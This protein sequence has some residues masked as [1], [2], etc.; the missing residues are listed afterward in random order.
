MKSLFVFCVAICLLVACADV[1]TPT[2]TPES[3]QIREEVIEVTETA[4]FPTPIAEIPEPTD[5]VD[6][7]PTA[8][9]TAT[10]VPTQPPTTVPTPI[11]PA[12]IPPAIWT[13][14]GTLMP[15]VQAILSPENIT[16]I[17]EVGRWGKGKVLDAKYSPDGTELAVATALGV[18][19]YDAETAVQLS[20]IPVENI[21]LASMAISPDWQWVAMGIEP[22]QI[23]IRQLSDGRLL[24]TFT[25][26]SGVQALAFTADGQHLLAPYAAWRMS[27]GV[28]IPSNYAMPM[29][30]NG[31]EAEMSTLS[32]DGK[33]AAL[34]QD[35]AYEMAELTV[36]DNVNVSTTGVSI[37]NDFYDYWPNAAIS[38]Y[39]QLLAI[40]ADHRVEMYQVSD[41]ALLFT[42]NNPV[43]SLVDGL[44]FTPDGQTLV[45]IGNEELSLWRVSDGSFLSRIPDAS[46]DI[47]FSADGKRLAAWSDTLTQWE[48]PSGT[49]LN[50]LKQH[51]GRVNDL[52]FTSTS[53]HLAIASNHLYLRNMVDGGL[54]TSFPEKT[55]GVVFTPDDQMLLSAS[56]HDLIIRN[57]IEDTSTIVGA[58]ES[59]WGVEDVAI[60]VDGQM[61]ATV[62]GD[63]AVRVW[64]VSDG[65]LLSEGY[66]MNGGAV[67]F[68][69]TE[70]TFAFFKQN[71]GAVEIWPVPLLSATEE[72]IWSDDQHQ[73]IRSLDI[74]EGNLHR[75]AFSQDGTLLAAGMQFSSEMIPIWRV[76]DGVLVQTLQSDSNSV[77]GIA[78]SPDGQLLASVSDDGTLKIWR[79]LD[80]VLL[81]TIQ[82]PP[83]GLLSVEFSPNGRYLTTGSRD[84][85]VRIWGVPLSEPP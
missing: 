2:V 33:I 21:Q 52:D 41:G 71:G 38:P 66:T 1:S 25:A 6:S 56:F 23:E 69:P 81:N 77:N 67:A 72:K 68:S 54:L 36:G 65:H 42:I 39:G 62:S 53:F 75:L 80:G 31:Y 3:S 46:G 18:Y 19:V 60:S 48:M 11:T 79:V 82:T 8:S 22:D 26:P 34:Y 51:A 7:T 78:F 50:Q 13:T 40:G 5:T 85:L 47:T 12:S 63:D 27:D 74:Q 28:P 44:E 10:A 43:P 15:P 4:V 84:G 70:P 16:H 64:Q 58:S 32:A 59:M 76:S 49:R 20:F 9:S 29:S 45:I 37:L 30:A 83:M 17:Q 55:H 24:N 73:P 57:M 14:I 61:V 35:H